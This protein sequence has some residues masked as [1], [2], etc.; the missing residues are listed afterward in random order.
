[1]RLSALAPGAELRGDADITGLAYDDRVVRAGDLFFCV[2]GLVVDGHD[3]AARAVDKGAV[4]LVVERF[5]DVD[6]PQARVTAVRPAMGEVAARFFGHPSGELTVAGVT[7]T[8]GKTTVTYLLESIG[9]AAGLETGV[10]STISRRYK[11]TEL[12]AP[13]TTPEAIDLQRLLREMADAGVDFVAMEA[14]SDGL[15][16]GRLIGT[17]FASAGFTNLTQDHLNTHG[18]MEAYFEAKAL[19]FDGSYAD[20]AVIN[21]GDPYGVRLRECVTCDVLT[22]GTGGADLVFDGEITATGIRGTVGSVE[23]A[24]PLVGRHNVDNCLCAIGIA[25]QCRIDAGAIA[26]GIATLDVIPGRLERVDAGQ[27]FLALV[28]YAHT[29]D[30]LD[31]AVRTCRE[32]ATGRLIVV[33]G[34]GGDRDRAKRPLMGEASSRVADLTIITSDNPRSE[35]PEAIV[36]E[37]EPGAKRGGGAY[38]TIVDREDA[39]RD[40]VTQARDGDVVLVAGKGHEQGQQFADRTVPFDDRDVIR[41]AVEGSTCRS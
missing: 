27:P 22:Y 3:F 26:R 29:P 11:G 2:P 6:V 32:L 34:C 16:Q 31:H 23:V 37:I 39:I 21:V 25:T 14:A 1:M 38:T 40:A 12:P 24:S 13:R 20:R 30:A 36:R 18:S 33:F 8:N 17:R 41:R 9:R 4:A 35:D 28:D 15:A 5:L 7:G 10:I 19:L